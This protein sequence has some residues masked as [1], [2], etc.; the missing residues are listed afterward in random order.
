M[1]A[2]LGNGG[3]WWQLHHCGE[4]MPEEA[5][6][7]TLSA[8]HA[9]YSPHRSGPPYGEVSMRLMGD[10]GYWDVTSPTASIGSMLEGG[11][12]KREIGSAQ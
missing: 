9:D 11:L 12:G 2:A 6:V 10:C 1:A 5:A 8:G 4:G 7:L 3:E